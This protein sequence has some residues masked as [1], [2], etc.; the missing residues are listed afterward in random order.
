M[1]E[2]HPDREYSVFHIQKNV[3]ISPVSVHVSLEGDMLTV[4][5]SPNLEND[6]SMVKE[7]VA[8]VSST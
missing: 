4:S 3:D 2:T 1:A 8:R 7:R 6:R 5:Y